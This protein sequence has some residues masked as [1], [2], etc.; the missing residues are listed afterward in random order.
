MKQQ[1]HNFSRRNFLKN[2]ALFGGAMFLSGCATKPAPRKLGANDRLNVALIGVG[3][4]GNLSIAKLKD[5]PMVKFSAFCDVDEN[6]AAKGYKEFPSVPRFRDYRV[7]LDKMDKE[8]DAVVI[9]TPDHMHYPISAW[10]MAKGKHVYCQKPLTR[11]IWESRKL[12]EL[13]NQSGLITQ[14]GNQGHTFDG[15]QVIKEW[16]DAGVLGQIESIHSWT[17]RPI[18]PQ[19]ALKRPAAQPVPE[20]LDYK[21]WLGVAPDA[22]YSDEVLPFKWRG[23]RDYGTGAGGDM[24]CHVLDVSYSAFEL[25]NPV[26]VWGDCSEYSDCAWPQ[27]ATS[28][29]E[30]DNKR[31]V[32]GKIALHWYDG[33]RKP[34]DIKRVEQSFIDD[35]RMKNGTLIVGTKETVYTNEY[36]MNPIIFPRARM[37][38][39][40]KSGAL[41]KKSLKRSEF[42]GNPQ[43]EWA[44]ACIDNVKPP[45]NFDYAAPFTEMSLLLMVPVFEK[46]IMEYDAANMRFKNLPSANKY[47]ASLYDYKKEFLPF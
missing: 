29:I 27:Q 40:K 24:A 16:Y 43:Q 3:G 32:G 35:P 45:A 10:A 37:V 25:D 1:L 4:I 34:K 11:T 41:P 33:G 44:K 19:G 15:W 20:T 42:A 2:T 12:R 31:G 6:R 28:H 22:P 39:L 47:L 38:E 14:M 26:K 21:L 8:I 13:A 46:E 17:D 30:F 5:C 36:G 9:S 18:W 7:M 23:F